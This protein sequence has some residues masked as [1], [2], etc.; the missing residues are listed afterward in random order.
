MKKIEF[1][2]SDEELLEFQ[3]CAKFNNVSLSDLIRHE[4][5]LVAGKEK[6]LTDVFDEAESMMLPL[7][8]GNLSDISDGDDELNFDEVE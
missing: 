2:V 8:S 6:H 5:H 7:G 3:K 4:L 1:K